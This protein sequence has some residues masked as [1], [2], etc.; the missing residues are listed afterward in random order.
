MGH[1]LHLSAKVLLH[2]AER[3]VFSFS[4]RLNSSV[5]RIDRRIKGTPINELYAP[6]RNAYD[7]LEPIKESSLR[8]TGV[9]DAIIA[10]GGV[11]KNGRRYSRKDFLNAQRLYFSN[12]PVIEAAHD[13][14]GVCLADEFYPDGTLRLDRMIGQVIDMKVVDADNSW[15]VTIRFAI[16]DMSTRANPW[17]ETMQPIFTK[18]HGH[19]KAIP[20]GIVPD[21]SGAIVNENG[22]DVVTGFMLRSI[23]LSCNSAFEKANAV[24]PVFMDGGR[25]SAAPATSS[26]PPLPQR[27]AAPQRGSIFDRRPI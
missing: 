22:V 10:D 26:R 24:Q 21:S 7:L 3:H 8:P 11:T 6:Y 27:Q 9:Y 2:E 15:Y 16:H 17:Y 25:M 4:P 13:P 1:L 19:Y 20:S 5:Q 23:I 14:L 18:L 12:Q